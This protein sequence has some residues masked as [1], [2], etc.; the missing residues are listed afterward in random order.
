MG[1][2]WQNTRKSI[3]IIL[4]CYDFGARFTKKHHGRLYCDTTPGQ[5][6]NF[7]IEIPIWLFSYDTAA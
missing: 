1:I 2:N 5:G 3:G 6:T 7:V 4:F